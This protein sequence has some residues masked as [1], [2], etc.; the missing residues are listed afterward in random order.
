[1]HFVSL[2]SMYAYVWARSY[3]SFESS[4]QLARRRFNH[5]HYNVSNIFLF[6]CKYKIINQVFSMQQWHSFNSS[7]L[8]DS[9]DAIDS[10]RHS[11]KIPLQSF[12]VNFFFIF[13][14]NFLLCFLLQNGFCFINRPIIACIHS[15]CPPFFFFNIFVFPQTNFVWK[16]ICCCYFCR[17]LLWFSER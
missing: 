3:T 17:F 5:R 16:R 10:Y 7:S 14:N 6:I 11:F 12:S 13:H 15:R 1:M 2:V 4:S 8:R 9:L